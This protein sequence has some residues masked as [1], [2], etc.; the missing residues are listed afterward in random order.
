MASLLEDQPR[1]ATA[2]ARERV[3]LY[4]LRKEDFLH[5]RAA[6]EPMRDEL[7]KCSLSV[8]VAESNSRQPP[9][10]SFLKLWSTSVSDSSVTVRVQVS[11]YAKPSR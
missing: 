2:V 10:R 6:F 5:A 9:R 1:N 4:A 11:A 8:F 3:E 7:M